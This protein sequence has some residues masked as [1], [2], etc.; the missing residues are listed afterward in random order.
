MKEEGREWETELWQEKEK[1][2][3]RSW[4]VDRDGGGGN[5]RFYSKGKPEERQV[6]SVQRF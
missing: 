5:K 4:S 6:N 2:G 1:S 3:A